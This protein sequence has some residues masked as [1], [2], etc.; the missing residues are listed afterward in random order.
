M[1]ANNFGPFFIYRSRL[2]L[3]NS[4]NA[5][6]LSP[7]FN[8]IRVPNRNELNVNKMERKTPATRQNTGSSMNFAE[9]SAGMA[10]HTIIPTRKPPRD[11]LSVP[12]S[13]PSEMQTDDAG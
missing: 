7:L 6:I 12:S 3:W 8:T 2:G 13:S 9:I 11:V 4:F 1:I 10:S 5:R